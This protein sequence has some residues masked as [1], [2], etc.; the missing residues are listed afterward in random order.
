MLLVVGANG[1]EDE[2]E[3]N[4]VG[5]SGGIRIQDA[6][7]DVQKG[8]AEL[9]VGLVLAEGRLAGAEKLDQARDEARER[10]SNVRVL[11]VL[12]VV[13]E[14]AGTFKSRADICHRCECSTFNQRL[15]LTKAGRR[16]CADIGHTAN[17]HVEID[18][19]RVRR[20][21]QNI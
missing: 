15:N 12:N 7:N 21:F 3:E 16:T 9:E 19:R 4:R 10:L 2:A 6:K 18:G 20:H 17:E 8:S 13:T 5:E 1:M 11:D 14:P